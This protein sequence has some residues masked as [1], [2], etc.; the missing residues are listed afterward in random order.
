MKF[1]AVALIA[2]ASAMKIRGGECVSTADSNELFTGIDTN[3]NGSVNKAEFIT[4]LKAFAKSQN[5]VPTDS[6]WAWV[7]K[8]AI[9]DAGADHVLSPAE[10]HTW[11]NQFASHFH[12]GG[13]P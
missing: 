9:K 11:V 3:H 12:I 4:G 8:T 6:D 2:T 5:Y 13:C 1:A 10:F 7:G